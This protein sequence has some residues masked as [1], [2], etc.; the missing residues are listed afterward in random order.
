MNVD[1][2]KKILII[3]KG[4]PYCDT[5]LADHTSDYALPEEVADDLTATAH[6][7]L[8]TW[9]EVSQHYKDDD[10]PLFGLTPKAHFLQHC[11]LLSRSCLS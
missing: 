7:Y 1:M 2:H 11:C 8:T 5:I 9:Y 3:L 4:S 10:V 6:I